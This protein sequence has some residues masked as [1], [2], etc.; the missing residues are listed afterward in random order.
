V[1]PTWGQLRAWKGAKSARQDQFA[2]RELT[3]R[4]R[5]TRAHQIG[6]RIEREFEQDR[7]VVM[8]AVPD[9]SSRAADQGAFLR[10]VREHPAFASM[11]A[12]GLSSLHAVARSLCFRADWESITSRPS[13]AQLMKDAGVSR[14]TVGRVLVKLERAGLLGRVASGRS[15]G[16]GAAALHSQEADGA[17][18]VLCV[19][20]PVHVVD[21]PAESSLVDVSETPTAKH[22]RGRSHP[23]YARARNDELDDPRRQCSAPPR[24]DVIA[25]LRQVRPGERLVTQRRKDE[26]LSA[27]LE[28]QRALPPLWS[29]STKHVAAV[30]REFVSAGWTMRDLQRAVDGRPD[31]SRWSFD[32]GKGVRDIGAWLTFRLS[33]W[34]RPDGSVQPSPTQRTLQETAAASAR[35][36]ARERVA[37]EAREQREL[38]G[39]FDM[40]PALRAV[41]DQLMDRSRIGKKPA[42]VVEVPAQLANVIEFPRRARTET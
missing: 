23:T 10:A 33:A 37:R 6:P 14:T 20:T 19:P 30:I 12:D 7:R 35:A 26:R 40:P 36:S 9:K 13:W 25:K 42:A 1:R 15:S 22:V 17:V 29:I 21:E 24:P 39:T 16:R 41:V 3:P 5:T 4:Q 28:L 32:G 27:A 31:G 18:Y 8:M 34:R 2:R 38:R 11:R